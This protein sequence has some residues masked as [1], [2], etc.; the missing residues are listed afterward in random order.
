MC[1]SINSSY[2][3]HHFQASSHE[4]H[5]KQPKPAN[6]STSPP[7]TG[8]PVSG[9]AEVSTKELNIAILTTLLHISSQ[10]QA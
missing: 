1:L 7:K 3:Q 9:F 4:K 8:N 6:I 2:L 10:V 5:G